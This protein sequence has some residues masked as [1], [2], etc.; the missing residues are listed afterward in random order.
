MKIDRKQAF[1]VLM[2]FIALAVVTIFG[3]VK[4]LTLKMLAVILVWVTL[5]SLGG[6]LLY[7]IWLLSED[8]MIW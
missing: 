7:L 2:T 4:L 6:M 3:L 8:F 1:L 5:V